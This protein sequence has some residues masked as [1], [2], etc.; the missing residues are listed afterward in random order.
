ML[1]EVITLNVTCGF[2]QLKLG[3]EDSKK[4]IL[5]TLEV[6]ECKGKRKYIRATS[7][8]ILKSTFNVQIGSEL[9]TGT[10]LDISSAGMSFIFD[11]PTTL[12]KNALLRKSY[13]FV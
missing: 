6:N 1:Y 2:I 12:S 13:N 11:E 7:N 8:N 10:I 5:K 3:K 9:K 4:I